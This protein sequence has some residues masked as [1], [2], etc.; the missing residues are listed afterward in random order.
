MD[1]QVN[2]WHFHSNDCSGTM[3]SINSTVHKESTDWF[4]RQSRVDKLQ[5]SVS[6]GLCSWNLGYLTRWNTSDDWRRQKDWAVYVCRKMLNDGLKLLG[7]DKEI[8]I[9]AQQLRWLAISAIWAALRHVVTSR[10]KDWQMATDK[11]N[12][13]TVRNSLEVQTWQSKWDCRVAGYVNNALQWRTR[14]S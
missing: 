13:V 3:H 11:G 8:T 2:G 10:D 6:G 12:H 14:H 5:P 4:R 7:D 1:I 9:E